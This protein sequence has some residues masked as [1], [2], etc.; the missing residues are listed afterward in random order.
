MKTLY[1]VRHA[2]SAWD[3]PM[4]PDE[5]RPLMD[6]GIDR[7]NKIIRHLKAKLILPDL[8]ITSQTI[9]TRETARLFA[10]GLGYPVEK[11]KIERLI[12]DDFFNKILEMICSTPD[13]VD[14]LM[15]FGHNPSMTQITNMFIRP[16]IDL[17]PTTG[18]SCMKFD[19]DSWETI[20]TARVADSFIVVPKML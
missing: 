16:G 15:V 4:I 6:V 8:M 9:R 3:D 2:K 1:L 13:E 18:V 10:L 14:S 19:T 17:M 12:Y 20:R 7:A 11:I 5:K